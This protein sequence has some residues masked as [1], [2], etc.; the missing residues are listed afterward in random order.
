M[1]DAALLPSRAVIEIKGEEARAFLNGLVTIDMGKVDQDHAGFAALLTPQGKI[2]FDFHIAAGP[3]SFFLDCRADAADALVKRL[4]LYRLRAKIAIERKDGWVVAAVWNDI[5]DISDEGVIKWRDPR[6]GSL[7]LRLIG[8]ETTIAGVIDDLREESDFDEYRLSLGVPE[9]GA[10]FGSEEMFLLDV[11]Y[12]AL[13]AVDYKKGCFVGQEV[14]SRM[15]RK[16]EIRKRTILLNYDEA[17][18]AKGDAVIAGEST[19]GQALS[20]GENAGL[21]MIRL[22]RLDAAKEAGQSPEIG[23]KPVQI[24]VPGYLEQA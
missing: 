11:N 19:L 12:D 15:K 17:A 24:I 5:P 22:D 9:L 13:G 3:D 7:G 14:S 1:T 23:G 8:M 4:T 6:L 18:P 16:G 2:L 21:A 20:S 10:D